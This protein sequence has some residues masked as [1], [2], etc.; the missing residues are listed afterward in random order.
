MLLAGTAR[1]VKR[2]TSAPG[3][4]PRGGTQQ[5]TQLLDP[6]RTI[7]SLARLDGTARPVERPASVLDH[8]QQGDMVTQV[9]HLASAL[10]NVRSAGTLKRPPVLGPVRATVSSAH[11]AGTVAVATLRD[12]VQGRVKLDDMAWVAMWIASALGRA[13]W[14]G[15]QQPTQLL[16]PPR[17]IA[18]LARLDGTARPVERPASVL[19]HAQ[20][21]GT[22]THRQ[23][24]ALQQKT[25]VRVQLEGMERQAEQ[26]GSALATV[27]LADTLR[28]QQ[29][30]VLQQETAWPV[31]PGDMVRWVARA[32][33]ARVHARPV[34]M[35]KQRRR[36]VSARELVQQ[37]GM[38]TQVRHL[39]SAPGH[40]PL[41]GTQ[42][43][44]LVLVPLRTTAS[45]V[46]LGA[47]E[48]PVER[49][50]CAPGHVLSEGT[51]S[52]KAHQQ[53]PAQQRL[54]ALAAQLAGISRWK[55]AI[56]L[57]IALTV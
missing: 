47:T 20:Q 4:A 57:Q 6:P 50:V 1:V 44:P 3:S 48:W 39:S 16:D 24:P 26:A 23:W 11:R 32:A 8:A 14:G 27:L 34:D 17:T 51:P 10:G 35:V 33:S 38:V 52:L 31:M 9:R 54:I 28:P 56:L 36:R 55:A 2:P 30:R 37:A 21:G 42:T 12:S 7:A 41:D 19:D 43:H 29:L 25:A 49:Q 45:L 18:S 40:A 15:T 53:L 46:Q 13:L 22:Q 5:P